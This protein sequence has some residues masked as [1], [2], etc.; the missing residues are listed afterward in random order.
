MY[1]DY[2]FTNVP[3]TIW[4][5]GWIDVYCAAMQCKTTPIEKWDD[6]RLDFHPAG[7]VEFCD[8]VGPDVLRD[9]DASTIK[10]MAMGYATTIGDLG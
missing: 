9:L 10:K 2:V 6:I 3:D 4:D 5:V 1:V 8:I 7:A